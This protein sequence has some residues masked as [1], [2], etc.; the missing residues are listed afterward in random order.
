MVA[1]QL[2]REAEQF[3]ETMQN[4][5]RYLHAHP[6]T[7]FEIQDAVC[8]V[9]KE[10]SDMG[11]EPV[12]C[13][14]A[15]VVALAGGKKPGKVFLLRADM[16]A[17]PIQEETGLPYASVNG[18]M[19]A[20]GHDMHTAMLLGAARLLKQH[21]ED[22]EG[23]VKLMFQPAEEI[24]EGSHDMIVS[25][26]L[27]NPKV[28][29]ALM[30]HVMARMP[31]PAGTVL[32]SAPG[33]SAPAADYFEIKVKGK[34]CHGSMPNTGV[35]PLQTAAHIVIAL[36]EIHAREL[37][38]DDRAV[39]TI[40]TMN[41]GIAANVIPDTA[42]IG[43]TIRTFDEEIRAFIKQ[44]IGEIAEGIAGSFR[45]EA[46]V[47]FGSGCPSLVN[48]KMLS[49]AVVKYG[50]EL[51][52]SGKIISVAEMDAQS[53]EKKAGGMAGSEDFAY[54]S[55]EVPSVMAALAAGEPA[56]GY[57]YPQHHPKVTFDESVLPVGCAMHAYTAMRWLEENK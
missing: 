25:G 40:G 50:R 34:G 52:G 12:D 23:T 31:F 51:F 49:Q 16:D 11:Y 44:R 55:Q 46:E 8:Y 21:E 53:G 15:G 27:E 41:A 20:C 26:L 54:V 45:A 18:K 32:V 29:A 57:L 17:L 9:K 7:G 36:Q 35:D 24:F 22:I 43:G 38:I 13:G 1:E 33:V 28:D 47:T 48:D 2:Q 30:F 19:H 4:E 5:R 39:L 14:K 37:A 10:L 6:G 56:K 42:V 3:Y